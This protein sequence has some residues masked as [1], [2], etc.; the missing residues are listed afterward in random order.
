V[1]A[2]PCSEG[3]TATGLIQHVTAREIKAVFKYIRSM[4]YA[5][6]PDYHYLRATLQDMKRRLREPSRG[7]VI[8]PAAVVP[9]WRRPGHLDTEVY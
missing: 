8:T 7:T 1:G 5:D 2:E 9:E 6:K 3:G 4:R